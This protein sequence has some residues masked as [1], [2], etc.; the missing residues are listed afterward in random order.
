MPRYVFKCADGHTFHR[1]CSMADKSTPIPCKHC[2][3]QAEH[4]LFAKV[5]EQETDDE[6][7]VGAN[8]AEFRVRNGK[9]ASGLVAAS[10]EC[11]ACHSE[12]DIDLDFND[13][14]VDPGDTAAGLTCDDCGAPL[15]RLLTTNQDNDSY[16]Y[17]EHD[18]SAGRTFH[19]RAERK[20]WMKDNGVVEFGGNME[21]R[22][23]DRATARARA[24]ADDIAEYKRDLDWYEHHPEPEVRKA[25]A[26]ANDDAGG[27]VFDGDLHGERVKATA[28][29]MQP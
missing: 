23:N 24:E 5:P 13:G 9:N 28:T 1:S 18:K 7:R 12:W 25:Y 29:L 26:K 10:F 17:G 15:R 8:G 22:I 21:N 2:H 16:R 6:V 19:T 20:K 27:R 4:D 11:T 14:T 3:E